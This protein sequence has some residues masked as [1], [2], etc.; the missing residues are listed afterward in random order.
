MTSL[1]AG[2][3]EVI[4]V[5]ACTNLTHWRRRD[6]TRQTPVQYKIED[7]T[8]IKHIPLTQFYHMNKQKPI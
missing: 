1:S 5:L 4:L 8:D 7:D 3:N 2:F 6:A